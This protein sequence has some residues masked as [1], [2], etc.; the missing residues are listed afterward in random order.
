MK[1]IF[2]SVWRFIERVNDDD[3]FG[4]S[5]QVA[6]YFLLAIF[7]MLFAIITLLPFFNFTNEQFL[8]FAE[9]F[10]PEG[11]GD[12]V[13]QILQEVATRPSVGLLSFGL[14]A[15]LWS[16]SSGVNASV[17]ALNRAYHVKKGR[18]FLI[19][20]VQSMGLTIG[21]MI[22]LL[23]TLL[24][25]VFGKQIGN[26]LF[27]GI[28]D[29]SGYTFVWNFLRW[30]V[31]LFI[32]FLVFTVLYWVGP[33]IK[34]KCRQALPGAIFASVGWI[35]SSYAFAFYINHFGNF[36]KVYGSLGG[37]IILIL[38]FYITGLFIILGGEL[39][40]FLAEPLE[41]SE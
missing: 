31:T 25:P 1:K 5:A 35:L 40:A 30:G 18:F 16:A 39:N 37:V 21:V 6:Y 19:Q 34:V 29:I 23:T 11:A 10:V 26:L 14:I 15:A 36:S 28:L 3:V 24:L 33:N 8:S 17:N 12:T 7:P 41:E 38:W 22:A 4:L 27:E 20:R 32:L 9:R 2:H 13:Y